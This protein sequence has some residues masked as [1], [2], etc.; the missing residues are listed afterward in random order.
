MGSCAHCKLHVKTFRNT[1][2]DYLVDVFAR[3]V[4]IW[5]V[6]FSLVVA[7]ADDASPLNSSAKVV[8]LVFVSAECPIANKFAPELE[9]LAR[10]Y[11]TNEVQ[12]ELVYPNDSDTEQKID[13]HRREYRLTARFMRDTK[14]VLV[15]KTGAT[16]TPEAAVFD[17]KRKLVYRGRVNDQYLALGKGRPRA[18]QHDLEDAIAA[19]LAGGKPRQAR[20]EAVGCFIQ[21]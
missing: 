19:I 9:R 4:L 18:T 20:T 7:N 10:K 17:Q 2:L 8:A 15:K 5:L 11:S 16:V 6:F 3:A 1:V 12:F 13:Q 14:H 21:K